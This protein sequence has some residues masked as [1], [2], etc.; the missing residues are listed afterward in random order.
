M[1]WPAALVSAVTPARRWGSGTRHRSS[2]TQPCHQTA[3][4][5]P[6][7]RCRTPAGGAHTQES[8]RCLA[9][10]TG[11]SAA[12]KRRLHASAKAC[13]ARHT[14]KLD[15]Q[16]ATHPFPQLGLCAVFAQ[17]VRVNLFCHGQACPRGRAP[18]T[19]APVPGECTAGAS[20][21][22]RRGCANVLGK[23]LAHG[24]VERACVSR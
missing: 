4:P 10:A 1:V 15:T 11:S 17:D 22:T 3:G 14:C 6:S 18:S 16:S 12:C 19:S 5:Q 2:S 7:T 23:A 8:V 13:P 20:G 9:T 24:D 21:G